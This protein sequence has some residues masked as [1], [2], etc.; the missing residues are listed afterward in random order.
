MYTILNDEQN[1]PKERDWAQGRK[2]KKNKTKQKNCSLDEITLQNWLDLPLV[3]KHTA[4]ES[5]FG[6]HP[7]YVYSHIF[8]KWSD[9]E[10]KFV[11]L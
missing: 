3:L 2:E 6:L 5:H 9:L 8:F 7:W 1:V 10:M 11:W 4:A